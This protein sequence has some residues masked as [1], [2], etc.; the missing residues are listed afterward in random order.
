MAQGTQHRFYNI[1]DLIL[2]SWFDFLLTYDIVEVNLSL[3]NYQ[4]E[5]T[6]GPSSWSSCKNPIR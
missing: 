5:V 3:H 2:C 6:I 4:I 1:T